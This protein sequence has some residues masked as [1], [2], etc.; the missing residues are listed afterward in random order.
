MSTYSVYIIYTA[1]LALITAVL[2]P[3]AHIR[4][5]AMLGILVGG[6]ADI[7]LIIVMR[8]LRIAEYINYGPFGFLGIP[9]FPSIAWTL[10]F[11]V[12]YYLLR[13]SRPVIYVYTA[14]A[15]LYSVLFSN[16]LVN[17]GILH[18]AHRIIVPMLLYPTWH[19]IAT[20]VYSRYGPHQGDDE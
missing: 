9:L 19:A 6:L 10:Y 18:L 16:V 12:Y 15:G 5:L 3:R 20:Y 2:V 1:T 14:A 13:G 8:T 11:I 17:L 4:R 7:G